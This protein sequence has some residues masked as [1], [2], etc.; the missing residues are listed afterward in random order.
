MKDVNVENRF[1]VEKPEDP[2]KKDDTF[3]GWYLGNDTEYK[4]D[5]VITESLTLYAKWRDGNGHEYL[6]TDGNAIPFDYEP[7]VAITLSVIVLV[8]LVVGYI[9]L[10]KKRGK[11]NEKA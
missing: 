8:G 9:Q 6:A 7:A 1:R 2:K 3:V 4:F 5:S 11:N 10:V